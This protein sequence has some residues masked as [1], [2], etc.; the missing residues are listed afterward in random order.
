MPSIQQLRTL[1]IRHW[2]EWTSTGVLGASVL[3]LAVL[4]ALAPPAPTKGTAT[5]EAQLVRIAG[6]AF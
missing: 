1:T 5:L 4:T 6:H 2:R 3:A